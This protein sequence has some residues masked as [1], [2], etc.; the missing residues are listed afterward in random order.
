MGSIGNEA[1]DKLAKAATE[2][3]SSNNNLLPKLLKNCL[4]CSLST[5]KQNIEQNTSNDTKQ[6]WKCLKCYRWINAID[7]TLP[8]KKHILATSNLLHNQISLLTQLCTS[9]IPLNHYL[10]CINHS[11]TPYC[12]HCPIPS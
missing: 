9:H 5:T 3:R 1:A 4:P 6:W 8:S 2:F 11:N 7:P 12:Q 10:H